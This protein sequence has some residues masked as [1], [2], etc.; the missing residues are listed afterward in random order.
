MCAGLRGGRGHPRLP[1]LDRQQ[2]GCGITGR[3]PQSTH[4]PPPDPSGSRLKQKNTK[5]LGQGKRLRPKPG[6][7]FP[8]GSLPVGELGQPRSRKGLGFLPGTLRETLF[9]C[10]QEYFSRDACWGH[11]AVETSLNY[12][13]TFH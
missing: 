13:E 4:T 12:G 8:G 1:L 3:R 9:P 7:L 10:T 2:A 6:V 11:R 5:A